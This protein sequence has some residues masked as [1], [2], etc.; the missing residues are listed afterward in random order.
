M[1]LQFFSLLKSSSSVTIFKCDVIYECKVTREKRVSG[2]C[3][4]LYVMFFGC[5]TKLV[6][7]PTRCPVTIPKKRYLFASIKTFAS[8]R[9]FD[10]RF[11][12]IYRELSEGDEHLERLCTAALVFFE[13][14]KA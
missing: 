5:C 4:W 3:T 6:V 14:M 10:F 2:N 11:Q 12:R 8:H 1:K 7:C 9:P 13:V